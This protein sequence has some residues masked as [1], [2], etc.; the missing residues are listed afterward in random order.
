[1]HQENQNNLLSSKKGV[2]TEGRRKK[3]EGK[4]KNPEREKTEQRE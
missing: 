4:E 3:S 1:M 2:I